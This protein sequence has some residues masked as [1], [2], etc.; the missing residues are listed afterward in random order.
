MKDA[1]L[2]FVFVQNGENVSENRF[3]TNRKNFNRRTQGA[4]F[5]FVF[6]RN[7]ENVS[8]N[9]FASNLKFFCETNAP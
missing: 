3:A 9:R 5:I 8:E 7:R 1:P 4:K 2:T 6:L